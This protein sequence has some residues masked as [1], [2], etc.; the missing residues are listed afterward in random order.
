MARRRLLLL[1]DFIRL[2]YQSQVAELF[3]A[4]DLPFRVEVVGPAASCGD[5]VQLVEE[6]DHWIEHFRPDAVHFNSGLEDAR[7]IQAE[8]RHQ[9]PLIDYRMNLQRAVE[10]L[11]SLFGG[12]IVFATTTQVRDSA[13]DSFAW[14]SADIEEYNIAACEVMLAED[15]LLNR[16]DALV[17][18]SSTELLAADGVQLSPDGA[19]L[20]AQRVID[21][22]LGVWR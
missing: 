2:S 10:K 5:S 12:E 18:P 4:S 6:L 19:A 14:S 21:S 17:G 11:E 15:V 8:R 16:L 9:V 1:G 20:T 22:V 13:D 3:Q 7:Y